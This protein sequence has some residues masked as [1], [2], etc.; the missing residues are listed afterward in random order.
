M[1]RWWPLIT[2]ALLTAAVWWKSSREAY[3]RRE[4]EGS[5]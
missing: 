2:V 3:L 4:G 1:K 5:R